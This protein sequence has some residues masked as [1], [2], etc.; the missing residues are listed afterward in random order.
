[1]NILKNTLENNYYILSNSINKKMIGNSFPQIQQMYNGYSYTKENSVHNLKCYSFP[2]TPP[3]L[4]SFELHKMAKLTDVLSAAVI[5]FGFIISDKAKNVIETFSLPSQSA[6]YRS[7]I[8]VK[9]E[10]THNYNFFY[11]IEDLSEYIDYDRTE[12]YLT[13]LDEKFDF[14]KVKSASE[15]KTRRNQIST[16][17]KIRTD[18]YFIKPSFTIPYD[19]FYISYADT[20][21]Y[22]SHRL[23]TALEEA[24]I[25][26][27]EIV[28]TDII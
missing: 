2:V 12:F 15:L 5:N 16:I 1:M 22:I 27:I 14:F 6:F 3:N 10:I 19:I 8:Y 25:T 13:D 9:N 24:N 28:P 20:R 4:H 18:K 17:K 21:T 23:K 7:S 11:F 26:G